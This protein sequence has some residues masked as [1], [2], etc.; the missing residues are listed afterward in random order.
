MKSFLQ[1]NRFREVRDATYDAIT[2][3]DH[4]A[5]DLREVSTEHGD[6]IAKGADV[7]GRYVHIAHM[8]R[9]CGKMDVVAEKLQNAVKT[10]R[11]ALSEEPPLHEVLEEH[12]SWSLDDP[13]WV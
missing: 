2:E 6:R 4:L 5:A 8:T 11:K 12:L 10:L 1:F 7:D 13:G 9:A 3:M